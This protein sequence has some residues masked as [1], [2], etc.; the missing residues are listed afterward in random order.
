MK[1]VLNDQVGG[2]KVISKSHGGHESRAG[3]RQV[4]FTRRH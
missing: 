4:V 1:D 3:D 2:V